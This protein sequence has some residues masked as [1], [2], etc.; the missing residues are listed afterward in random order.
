MEGY[1]RGE[2][3]IQAKQVEIQDLSGTVVHVLSTND[4]DASDPEVGSRTTCWY[5]LEPFDY[6]LASSVD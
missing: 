3:V 1:T 4:L 2:K 6:I 5:R